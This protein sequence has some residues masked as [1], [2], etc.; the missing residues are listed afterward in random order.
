MNFNTFINDDENKLE[1]LPPDVIRMLLAQLAMGQ[2]AL[3]NGRTYTPSE[4]T[5]LVKRQQ[6]GEKIIKVP[7]YACDFLAQQ[8]A[9][10]YYE[11][12][13]VDKPHIPQQVY[14]NPPVLKIKPLDSTVSCKEVELP[15]NNGII[16]VRGIRVDEKKFIYGVKIREDMSFFCTFVKVDILNGKTV[17]AA[18]VKTVGP[19]SQ[20]NLTSPIPWKLLDHMIPDRKMKGLK[21]YEFLLEHKEYHKMIRTA[22]YL[23]SRKDVVPVLD[24]HGKPAMENGQYL[25]EYAN[26]GTQH[27]DWTE[28]VREKRPAPLSYK[29]KPSY[30]GAQYIETMLGQVN[31]KN[32]VRVNN[33]YYDGLDAS[34]ERDAI[35]SKIEVIM[36][37]SAYFPNDVIIV[38]G[39]EEEGLALQKALND[40]GIESFIT[41][42]RTAVN[43][44]GFHIWMK[45]KNIEENAPIA[46]KL[47]VKPIVAKDGAILRAVYKSQY[48]YGFGLMTNLLVNHYS[49][50]TMPTS[51]AV[52]TDPVEECIILNDQSPRKKVVFKQL[53]SKKPLHY[54]PYICHE[55]GSRF[56][57]TNEERLNRTWYH[58][59]TILSWPRSKIPYI[60]RF[61]FPPTIIYWRK[62]KDILDYTIEDQDFQE[63]IQIV[64]KNDQ[65]DISTARKVVGGH[66][67]SSVLPLDA[68]VPQKRKVEEA[69]PLSVKPAR[70]EADNARIASSSVVSTVHPVPSAPPLEEARRRV[71]PPVKTF[72]INF[73][74]KDEDDDI[75]S[76]SEDD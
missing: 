47:T 29:P 33:A 71:P 70:P 50:V 66:K 67:I 36:E 56:P 21:L 68:R 39:V 24:M 20:F 35:R 59:F 74:V 18:N 52:G 40:K 61:K 51:T 31:K 41:N 1:M 42:E 58:M 30:Q 57:G 53:P 45:E 49:Q 76:L 62:G 37:Y 25:D 23:M 5:D 14:A 11:G 4:V 6:S 12:N 13:V 3:Y 55:S 28:L 38:T 60:A 27:S 26:S 2:K 44:K 72:D 32:F 63:T 7:P 10:V 48:A 46:D 69:R 15:V 54:Y 17:W 75:S 22:V 19:Y 9:V 8:G 65:A 43:Y 64:R 34:I 16:D 73:Y